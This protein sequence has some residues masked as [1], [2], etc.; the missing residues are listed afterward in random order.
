MPAPLIQPLPPPRQ[1]PAQD[2]QAIDLEERQA[3]LVSLGVAIA[4][5]V[6]MLLLVLLVA[7]RRLAG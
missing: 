3:Q 7:I 5:G 6:L 1:L 2:H 4:A